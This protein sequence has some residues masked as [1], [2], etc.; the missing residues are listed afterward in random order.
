MNLNLINL[1]PSQWDKA[2]WQE[3]YSQY[4]KSNMFGPKTKREY[5]DFVLARSNRIK[6]NARPLSEE[7]RSKWTNG[8]RKASVWA[9]KRK[10]NQYGQDLENSRPEIDLNDLANDVKDIQWQ[11]MNQKTEEPV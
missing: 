4:C 10:C 2:T 6:N 11:L 9:K 7:L 1:E 5:Y 3:A 8:F